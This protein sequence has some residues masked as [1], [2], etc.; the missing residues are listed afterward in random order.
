MNDDFREIIREAPPILMH[1]PLAEF[2]GAFQGSD[3]TLSYTLAD[4]VKLAGHCCPTVTGAY[5]STREALSGLYGDEIPVRG[6]ISVTA[7]GR[8]GEGVYGV[9]SQVMAY[10]TG[11]APETGFKGL[12]PRFRR[13]GLLT[14]SDGKPGDEAVSFRFRRQDD[15]G[16]ILV[17]ILPWLVPFPEDKARRSAELMEK[18]MG[19]TADEAET[20]DR[21]SVV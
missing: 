16:S 15:G 9:M 14:F 7:L 10:I 21:K 12:G 17:R 5:L 6:E 4:T 18:V 19:G 2:L 20:I 1:E 13:Q 3:S 11:A 8:P